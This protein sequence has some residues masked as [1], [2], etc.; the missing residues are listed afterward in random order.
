MDAIRI[1]G[2]KFTVSH[3]VH[4]EEKARPQLFEVDVEIFRDLT[5]PAASDR[6]E[7]TVDYSQVVSSV[8]EV[9]KGETCNLLERLAGKILNALRPII[10]CLLYTSPSPRD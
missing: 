4:P 5:K 6:I 1:L 10:G 7:D 8:Q 9:M 2:L 3:G